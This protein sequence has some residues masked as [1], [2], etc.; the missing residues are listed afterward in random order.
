MSGFGCLGEVSSLIWERLHTYL[1]GRWEPCYTCGTWGVYFTVMSLECLKE[2]SSQLSRPYNSPPGRRRDRTSFQFRGLCCKIDIF[3]ILVIWVFWDV[4]HY[5][6]R[7]TLN[8]TTIHNFHR[9]SDLHLYNWDFTGN[10]DKDLSMCSSP[11]R[12][13]SLALVVSPVCSVLLSIFSL[14]FFLFEHCSDDSYPI[15]ARSSQ[16]SPP[17]TASS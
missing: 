15:W 1:F 7:A 3:Q 9:H 13:L 12:G 14:H 6:R 5:L 10:L 17:R 8:A 4:G 2:R 11:S 16:W